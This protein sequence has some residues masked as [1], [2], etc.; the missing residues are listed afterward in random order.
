MKP[1]LYHYSDS[2]HEI[3]IS[4]ITHWHTGL[5]SC[6]SMRLYKQ[7]KT[8][9]DRSTCLDIHETPT[10]RKVIS[11]LRLSSHKLAIETCRHYKISLHDRKC[12]HCT[13]NDIEDEFHFVLIIMPLL[14]KFQKLYTYQAI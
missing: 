3:Y 13:L 12:T 8:T 9:I 4:V 6:T 14:F 5:N 2:D 11:Q 7:I 1:C 10:Y